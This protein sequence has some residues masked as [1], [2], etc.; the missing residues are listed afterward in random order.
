MSEYLERL[1][2]LKG[3]TALVTGGGRGL[4]R[5]FA[6]GLAEAGAHVIVASRKVSNCEGVVK[7]IQDAGGSAEAAA[8]SASRPGTPA[9]WA[10]DI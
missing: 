9:G 4:G 5:D 1:F 10:P 8:L 6:M 2:G 3:R 7:E